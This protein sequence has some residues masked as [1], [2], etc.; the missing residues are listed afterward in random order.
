[1]FPEFLNPHMNASFVR[2]TTTFK[3]AAKAGL[4]CNEGFCLKVGFYGTLFFFSNCPLTRIMHSS[5][6]TCL[7]DLICSDIVLFNSSSACWSSTT[8]CHVIKWH[9]PSE[10]NGMISLGIKCLLYTHPSLP[11]SKEENIKVE[12]YQWK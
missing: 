3:F 11:S 4:H 7:L 2:I 12:I 1:M 6:T 5:R 9:C 10:E 8:H